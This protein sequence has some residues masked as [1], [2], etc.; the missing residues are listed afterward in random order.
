MNRYAFGVV[1]S[2][3]AFVVLASPAAAL[4]SAPGP[5]NV[6]VIP[7]DAIVGDRDG[8]GVTFDPGLIRFTYADGSTTSCVLDPALP[9]NP[10]AEL[11]T[12]PGPPNVDVVPPEAILGEDGVLLG[13]VPGTVR[14]TYSDGTQFECL[15]D[16]LAP[17]N[18]CAEVTR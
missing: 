8:A 7:P 9:P 14:I 2:L 4:A 16:P 15:L 1:G 10:C 5:P 3:L 6:E 12:N 18:P 17:P 11:A 13:F